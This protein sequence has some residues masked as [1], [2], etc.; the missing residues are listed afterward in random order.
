MGEAR[1]PE[2][3]ADRV[4]CI[5]AKEPLLGGGGV[6]E[7]CHGPIQERFGTPYMRCYD[8]DLIDWGLA[9][10][11]AFALARLEDPCEGE[12][13]VATRAQQAAIAVFERWQKGI[14]MIGQDGQ[15][16]A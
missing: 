8:M 7:C 15:V 2:T 14:D 4:Y 3:L 6:L 11:L 10:G 1:K 12:E 13:S 16:A 9:C 5:V